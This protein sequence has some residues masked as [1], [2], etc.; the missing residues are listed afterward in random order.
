MKLMS[1]YLLSSSNDLAYFLCRSKVAAVDSHFSQGAARVDVVFDRYIGT[2]SIKSQTRVQRGLH[3]KKPIRKVSSN[4]LSENNADLAAFLSEY[5]VK[6]FPNDPAGCELVLGGA[7]SAQNFIT[8]P[9]KVSCID[10]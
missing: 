6:R 2:Q 3:V 8:Q 1:S 4:S 9:R 10:L 5:I 7:L